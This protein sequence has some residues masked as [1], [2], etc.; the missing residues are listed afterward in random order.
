MLLNKA[1]NTILPPQQVPLAKKLKDKKKWCKDNLDALEMIGRQQFFNNLALKENY[2]I[3]KGRF[4]ME[5][6]FDKNDYFDITS[7]VSQEFN[8]PNYLKH[9]DITSKGVN[10]LV[11]EF[12]KRP[13]IYRVQAMDAES[14]NEYIRVKTDLLQ[15]YMLGQVKDEITRKLQS[16]GIDVDR[17]DFENEEEAQQYQQEIEQKFQELTP[18]AIEKYMKYDFRTA[19]ESWG[20]AVLNNDKE[21]FDLASK[22]QKE[23]EDML[24]ADRCFSHFFLVPTGYSVETWNPI[25]T[26]FHLSPEVEFVEDGDYVGRVFYMSKSQV[27]D[28]YGWKMTQDEIEALYPEY[29]RTEKGDDVYSEFFN[30][31]FF[32]WDDY[33]QFTNQVNT[34]GFDPHTG[35]PLAA[36]PV[37]DQAAENQLLNGGQYF[38]TQR[39]LVQVTEAYWKSQRKIGKVNF[40][41]PETEEIEVQL[42]DELFPFQNYNFKE[43]QLSFRDSDE[44]NTI[45]WAW[46]PQIWKGIKVNANYNTKVEQRK[47]MA[48]YLDMGPN[49]FQFKG[50]FNPFNPKLPVC[51]QIFNNRNGRSMSM[52]DLLKPYQIFYNVLYNQAYEIAQRNNGKFFLMD[53]N[54]L[55]NLKDWGGENS[56]EKFMAIA[57][58]LGIGLVDSRPGNTQGASFQHYQTVDLDESKR[59]EALINLA[60]LVEQQAYLQLGITPQRAGQTQASE[61]AT[62][63]Q[64][65]IN[66]S[67][68]QTESYFEKFYHYKKRKLRMH[69][70]IAQFVA[71]KEDDITLSYITS[72]LTRAF[73]KINGIELL[74]RDL[75][76]YVVNSQEAVRQLELT[77]QLAINNNTTKLP[78]SKLVSMIKLNSVE[79]IQKVL[80]ESEDEMQKQLMAEQQQAAQLQQEQLQAQAEEADKVRENENMNKQLDRETNIK[81]AE[82]KALGMDE[83]ASPEI[84]TLAE[85]AAEVGKLEFERLKAIQENNFKR[86]QLAKEHSLQQQQIDLKRREMKLKEDAHK[87]DSKLEKQKMVNDLKIAKIRKP[88]TPKK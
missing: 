61:T 3:I 11:G 70:D 81:I 68:S 77:R 51:G 82:L 45:A 76:V 83:G 54:I 30:A 15:A 9:Y 87:E 23:F 49:E 38:F 24:V 58:G 16:Q 33:R 7:A 80:E 1:I 56:Y 60:M 29:Y 5:H 66:N 21:R 27:I 44:P 20:Q 2:D 40:L 78:M 28:R 62:G 52:V 17:S 67:Y 34:L 36:I 10:I 47:G 88:K 50:D 25:N 43:V 64:Q 72:D 71:S 48:T 63:V 31:S 6:Y 53:V 18:K 41:N 37:L 12:I 4:I 69:L 13:D 26:F 22:E 73:I 32:P 14:Q 59:V 84:S 74:L 19:A 46:V 57:K 79:D 35:M 42:V 65:A 55:P 75:G 39:D 8:L 86:L 85:D